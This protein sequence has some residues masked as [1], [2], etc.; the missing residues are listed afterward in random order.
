MHSNRRRAS[1]RRAHA[2]PPRPEL[3]S[4]A[5]SWRSTTTGVVNVRKCRDGRGLADERLST[6]GTLSS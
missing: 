3:A 4:P 5:S 1:P 6:L 2:V